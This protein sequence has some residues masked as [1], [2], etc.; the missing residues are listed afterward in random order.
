MVVVTSDRSKFKIDFGSMVDGG[1][2]KQQTEQYDTVE[3]RGRE[4]RGGRLRLARLRFEIVAIACCA[5]EIA[6]GA[7]RADIT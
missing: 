3:R 2:N 4:A 7:D 1:F 6:G 5:R